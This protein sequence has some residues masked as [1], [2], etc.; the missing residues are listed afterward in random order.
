[1]KVKNIIFTGDS[2]T[3]GEG[4]E[5]YDDRCRDFLEKH[6]SDRNMPYQYN[7]V[8][9]ITTDNLFSNIR[10]QYRFSNQVANQ[11]NNIYFSPPRNGGDT[12]GGIH[13]SEDILNSV[14]PS[15][16][17]HV[18]LNLTSEY[19]SNSTD[20][21]NDWFSVKYKH[22]F[23]H[24]SE[25]GQF[26]VFWWAYLNRKKE[27]DSMK[28]YL[29]QFKELV[30]DSTALLPSDNFLRIVEENYESPEDF[31]VDFLEQYYTD[32]M[33]IIKRIE[34]EYDVKFIIINSWQYH[35]VKFFKECK[36]VYLMKDYNERFLKIVDT[37]IPY[38]S[39]FELMESNKNK[40]CINTKYKWTQNNHMTKEA[41]DVVAKSIISRLSK[42]PI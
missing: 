18:V 5:L 4:V 24:F 2:F 41:H 34:S 12:L 30:G 25:L 10:N 13:F 40:Y 6:C 22:T 20:V 11:L 39:L 14:N 29:N 42:N 32:V 17:S 7:I 19:R 31:E 27:G 33:N 38:G 35:T 15:S 26:F 1:M 36:N 23:N 9:D 8:M 37:N 28:D 3:W 16:I 21:M